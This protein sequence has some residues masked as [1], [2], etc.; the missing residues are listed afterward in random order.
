MDSLMYILFI[1]I[2]VPIV[3]MLFLLEKKS[4]LIA[5]FM[6]IGMFIC[7]FVSEIN[8][9]LKGIL[10]QDIYTLSTTLT[11]VTREILKAV[12]VLVFAYLFSDELETLVSVSMALGIG[13]AVLENSY[14][15]VSNMD[16]VSVFLALIRGFGAGLM[17]GICT[18]TVG[19]G[20]SFVRKKKKLFYTGI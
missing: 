6:L 20:M 12:P 2:A 16:S 14:V 1:C 13:F 4:R 15:I 11:P 17:H 7:M 9:F 18:S 10:N 3:M 19:Y 8:G 5:G